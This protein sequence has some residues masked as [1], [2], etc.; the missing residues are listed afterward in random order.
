MC[1]YKKLCNFNKRDEIKN[2]KLLSYDEFL[3][4]FPIYS[5]LLPSRISSN[6]VNFYLISGINRKN[7]TK[8]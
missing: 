4:E 5:K 2:E 3:L 8:F 1:L 7:L 6:F